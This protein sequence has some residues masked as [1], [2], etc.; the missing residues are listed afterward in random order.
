MHLG[1]V[2]SSSLGR[3]CCIPRLCASFTMACSVT[4]TAPIVVC[5]KTVFACASSLLG[6][7][8]L[9]FLSNLSSSG[10]I[11]YVVLNGLSKVIIVQWVQSSFM[12]TLF[13]QQISPRASSLYV[14]L[15]SYVY[16]DKVLNYQDVLCL[17]IKIADLPYFSYSRFLDSCPHKQKRLVSSL[18][19]TGSSVYSIG[20]S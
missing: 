18:L 15:S 8:N 10:D 16:L 9:S 19:N 17:L 2:F 7:I 11:L 5:S 4:A 14:C 3:L 12:E 13:S 20:I 1:C 6:S